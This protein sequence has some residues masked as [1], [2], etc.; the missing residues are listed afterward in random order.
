M[1]TMRFDMRAPAELGASPSDLYRAALEM[2]EWGERRGCLAIQLS[3]HHGASDGYLPAPLVL[4]SAIAART[5]R[6]PIQVAATAALNGPQEVVHEARAT[7][8]RRRDVLVK[9]FALA[10]WEIPAP[11]ATMFAWAP[12]PDA[13][14]DLGSLEFSKL[15]LEK[16]QVAV[17]PGIGFGEYGEGYV[18]IALVE[19]RQRIMQ[20]AR[21]VRRFLASGDRS[22][23]D[24]D[25]DA[26]AS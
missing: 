21:N 19:N 16:A 13:Y 11:S 8:L 12:L 26:V 17:S 3:E 9:S 10:G 15:L 7:Y 6:T 5:A 18:R 14:E 4:A 25:S 20:A 23:T 2:A 1:F 24:A 22:L